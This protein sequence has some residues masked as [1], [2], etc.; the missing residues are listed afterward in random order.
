MFI[1]IWNMFWTP[2]EIAFSLGNPTTV[3]LDRLTDVMFLVDMIVVLRTSFV[4]EMGE[5]ITN[6]RD[7]ALNYLKGRF[8][9]DLICSI[10]FDLIA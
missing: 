8:L 5:E 3:I 2:L 1:S 7:I 4:G 6:W 9:I 10:P